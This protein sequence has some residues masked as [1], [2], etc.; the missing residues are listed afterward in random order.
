M[1]QE[2]RWLDMTLFELMWV[3][4]ERVELRWSITSYLFQSDFFCFDDLSCPSYLLHVL[5]TSNFKLSTS[6]IDINIDIDIITYLVIIPKSSSGLW[7]IS[8]PVSISTHPGL[9][10]ELEEVLG[11]A[12]IWFWAWT[13]KE[14]ELE[15][16]LE[17]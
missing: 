1:I 5:P 7:T 17:L 13:L 6:D 12:C 2:G 15:L 14:L 11:Y 10:I 3:D 4:C 8:T 9:E 16:E